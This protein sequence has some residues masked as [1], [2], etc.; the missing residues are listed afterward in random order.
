MA[1]DS[2]INKVRSEP[3][4]NSKKESPFKKAEDNKEIKEATAGKE[5]IAE[6]VDFD[7]SVETTGRVSEV[8]KDQSEQ[9]GGSATGSGVAPIDPEAIKAK[10][11]KGIPTEKEM[12]KQIEGEI[13]KEIKYLHKKAIK[14]MAVPN[15]MSFF[16]MT[17]LM[18]KIR[19]LKGL[20]IQLIKASLENLKTLWLRFVHGV[21]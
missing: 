20:L 12:R 9:K 3:S 6:A 2:Q 13:K 19:E 5:A 17:N 14:L 15:G 11:L 1:S 7:E 8:I 16:E 18:K 4:L 10:L 21:M